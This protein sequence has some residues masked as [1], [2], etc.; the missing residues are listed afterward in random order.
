[1]N[2][3]KTLGHVLAV[4]DC[5]VMREYVSVGLEAAGLTVRTAGSGEEALALVERED[6]DAVVLDYDMP[7]LTGAQVGSALRANPHTSSCV[8]AMHTSQAEEQVRSSGFGEFDTFIDK[9]CE[10]RSLGNTVARLVAI[11]RVRK[12]G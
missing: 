12:S 1:M 7:G 9:P 5:P 6:F 10:P 8:I 2:E 3:R 4:D 11:R